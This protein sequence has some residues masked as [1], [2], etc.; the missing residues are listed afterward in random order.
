MEKESSQYVDKLKQTIVNTVDR[1]ADA[2]P[3]GMD[4]TKQ[5][6]L[7]TGQDSNTNRHSSSINHSFRKN[8]LALVR[9]AENTLKSR[10]SKMTKAT[11]GLEY[12]KRENKVASQEYEIKFTNKAR[13]RCL[14]VESSIF[15]SNKALNPF[16]ESKTPEIQI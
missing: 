2:S 11:N 5:G 12:D 13:P 15:H 8:G 10:H 4:S 6:T 1:R 16:K 14:P 9:T 3:G 7:M